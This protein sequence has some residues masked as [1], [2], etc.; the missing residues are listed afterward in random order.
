M[1][2]ANRAISNLQQQL[3]EKW[4]TEEEFDEDEIHH[5]YNSFDPSHPPPP[6]SSSSLTSLANNLT[7]QT[8]YNNELLNYI[9]SLELQLQQSNLNY[10]NLQHR[11]YSLEQ[12][13][14]HSNQR[15][16]DLFHKLTISSTLCDELASQF[17]SLRT[18]IINSNLLNKENKQEYE[19]LLQKY[20]YLD[21]QNQIKSQKIHEYEIILSD[22]STTSASTQE[23]NETEMIHLKAQCTT[24]EEELEKQHQRYH[25]MIIQFNTL[26]HENIQ[27]HST[28][29]YYLKQHDEDMMHRENAVLKCKEISLQFQNLSNEKLEILIE[30]DQLMQQREVMEI[31]MSDHVIS[32]NDAVQSSKETDLKW[33]ELEVDLSHLTSTLTHT[34]AASL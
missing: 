33:R 31:Q 28:I 10:E 32:R 24:L 11:N 16:D 26:Q 21:E 22:T 27:L 29:E 6:P 14:L 5:H 18:D 1:S 15:G 3:S 13:L 20:L 2:S 8:E 25:E 23:F 19:S 12:D 9:S 17:Q 34:L 30:R 7:T 4:S